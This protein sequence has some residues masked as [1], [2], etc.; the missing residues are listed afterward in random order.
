MTGV[1]IFSSGCFSFLNGG[2]PCLGG[3]V[4]E[5]GQGE[6][7]YLPGARAPA[8]EGPSTVVGQHPEA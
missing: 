7:K 8:G 1:K 6:G 4:Q 5:E 2:G 3:G